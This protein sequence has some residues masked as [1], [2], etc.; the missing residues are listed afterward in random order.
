MEI[1]DFNNRINEFYKIVFRT[2]LFWFDKKYEFDI[3][4]DNDCDS[5]TKQLLTGFN[6]LKTKKSRIDILEK[7]I[8]L[9]FEKLFLFSHENNIFFKECSFTVYESTFES[10]FT[11]YKK[12]YVDTKLIDFA[13]LE[14]PY[15]THNTSSILFRMLNKI[16][17]KRVSDSTEKKFEFLTNKFKNL[18]TVPK[19]SE[20][21]PLDLSDSKTLEKIALLYELGI[22]DYLHNKDGK[23]H[24]V[25]SIATVLSGITGIKAKTIQSAIN[26][27]INT[28]S[29]SKGTPADSTLTKAKEKIIKLGF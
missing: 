14:V 10:R 13:S 17:R 7:Y 20:T 21:E 9:S 12:T 26:P 25:N 22:I 6:E 1:T 4:L 8:N 18:D 28:H 16:N 3:N 29:T 27:F 19:E 24:T 11:E 2:D 5:D 15:L 23:P